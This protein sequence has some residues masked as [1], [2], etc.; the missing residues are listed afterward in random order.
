LL[1]TKSSRAP[2]TAKH[3]ANAEGIRLTIGFSKI[4]AEKQKDVKCHEKTRLS[5]R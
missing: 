3:R 1:F 2:N 5:K 4:I